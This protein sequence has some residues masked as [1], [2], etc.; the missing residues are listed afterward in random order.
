M[1]DFQQGDRDNDDTF[2]RHAKEPQ[3]ASIRHTV[4]ENNLAAEAQNK[5]RDAKDATP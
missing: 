5:G 2:P 4:A 1:G 3:E